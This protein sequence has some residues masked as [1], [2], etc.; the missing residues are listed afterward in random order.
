MQL[1]SLNNSNS[2]ILVDSLDYQNP[3]DY[4]K[5]HRHSYYEIFLIEKGVGG[6]Q[7]IDF[8]TYRL[9]DRHLYI[10]VPNQVHLL[11]R[12]KNEMGIILQFTHEYLITSLNNVSADMLFPLKSNPETMLS[13]SEYNELVQSFRRLKS[14]YV[15]D[16]PLK[17]E[18]L[19]HYFSYTILQIL[20]V[21]QS[22][23]SK[24]GNDS[25]TIQFLQMAEKQFEHM[26]NISEYAKL[27]NISVTKLN[28]QIKKDL[29]KTPLQIIHD[30][31]I[32]EIKRLIIIEQI[33]H[34]EISHRLNFDSQ[35]S[36]SRFVYKQ[37]SCKPSELSNTNLIL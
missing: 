21:I 4:S 30:L 33:S 37:L 9:R 26:R 34:K 12:Q 27:L 10:I 18:K 15:S 14:L 17:Y 11:K 1:H 16:E 20:G 32:V 29:G 31:L 19:C 22:S 36:Y 2:S 8:N 23:A 25:L 7:Q 3:Y 28:T 24:S 5:I 6:K 35:S 13:D